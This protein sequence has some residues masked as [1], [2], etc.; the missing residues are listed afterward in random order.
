MMH[1]IYAII[2]IISIISIIWINAIFYIYLIVITDMCTHTLVLS[3]MFVAQRLGPPLRS[4]LTLVRFLKAVV[5]VKL[6]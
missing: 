3:I 2:S 1:M 4:L 5:T 6:K